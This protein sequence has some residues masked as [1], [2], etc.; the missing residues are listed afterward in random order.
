MK[1][2]AKLDLPWRAVG[3]IPDTFKPCKLA[4]QR[5]IHEEATTAAVTIRQGAGT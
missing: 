3:Y 4:R 1:A 5:A 2:L